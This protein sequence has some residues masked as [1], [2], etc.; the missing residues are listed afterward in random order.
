MIYFWAASIAIAL[1]FV[2]YL[3][4]LDKGYRQAHAKIVR[5][6]MYSQPKEGKSTL[7]LVSDKRNNENTT[8]L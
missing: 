1:F 5:A 6:Q 8:R 2:G 3:W 4:G 7:R